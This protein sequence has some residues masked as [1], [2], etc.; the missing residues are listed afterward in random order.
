M[1]L[2]GL[3]KQMK[4]MKTMVNAAPA[5]VDQAMALGAQAQQMGA[6]QQAAMGAQM[7]G[8]PGPVDPNDPMLAPIAGIDLQ[9]YAQLSKAI[10]HYGL[11]SAEQ[12]DEYMTR[13]GHTPEAWQ[14]AY[15][16][17]NARFKANMSLSMLYAQ[18]FNSVVL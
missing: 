9:R 5:M 2:M 7:G 18:Y 17:W 16:G 12:I 15:D 13:A 1:L 10:G 14:E 11:R 4:D 6:A 3:F 8:M